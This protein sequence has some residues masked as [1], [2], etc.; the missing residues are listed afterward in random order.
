MANCNKRLSAERNSRQSERG[1]GTTAFITLIRDFELKQI[2]H[3]NF[4]LLFWRTIR[5][6]KIVK[7]LSKIMLGLVVKELIRLLIKLV[8]E[9]T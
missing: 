3:E 4:Q 8:G 2:E 6:I 9:F 1:N 7:C 5:L